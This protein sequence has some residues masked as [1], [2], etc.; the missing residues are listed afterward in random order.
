MIVTTEIVLI[1][2][3]E[4]PYM[5]EPIVAKDTTVFFLLHLTLLIMTVLFIITLLDRAMGGI[6]FWLGLGIALFV[7]VLYPRVVRHLGVAPTR[8][9]R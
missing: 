3:L 2:G 1:T 4:I 7:G 5:P 8:W 9:E 6:N